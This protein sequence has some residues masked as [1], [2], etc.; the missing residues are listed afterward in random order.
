MP[1]ATPNVLLRYWGSH[2]KSMRQARD[3]ATEFRPLRARGWSCH[4][5]VERL[6]DDTLW[7]RPLQDLEVGLICQPRPR[8]NFDRHC[9]S[10]VR[11]LCRELGTRVFHCDNMHMSPLLG[12]ALAAVPVRIWSKRSMSQHFEESR[13][14]SWKERWAPSTRFSCRLATRV[15]AVSQAVKDELLEMG[16]PGEKILVRHDPR[17]LGARARD[18][19]GRH[20][21]TLWGFAESDVV[22][23]TI[24]HA[25]PV[26]G[27]DVLLRAF[28][29]VAS[30]DDRA[31]LLVVGSQTSEAERDH[32]RALERIIRASSLESHVRFAGHVMDIQPALAAA[33]IYVSPSRSEGFS[34]A[35]VEAMEAGLPCVATR[36]GIAPQAIQDGVNGLLVDRCDDAGLARALLRLATDDALRRQFAAAVKV[37][38]C[39]PTLEDYAERIARDYEALL[40]EAQNDRRGVNSQ[41]KR[42]VT[43]A[44]HSS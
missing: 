9:V 42:S 16:I 28:S 20:Q 41:G 36:V 8:A 43:T 2:F 35:L 19:Q 26:K 31:R 44:F 27:W 40:A 24:G 22:I 23:V 11:R 25:V 6:P 30:R 7:L 34:L 5:V 17:R 4:L 39:I 13:P 37:P 29:I 32:F 10:R 15:M 33:D 1:A 21:R 18:P 3:F 12:A 14:P 38:D